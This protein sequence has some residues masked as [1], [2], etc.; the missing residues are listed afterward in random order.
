MI[1]PDPTNFYTF[2]TL[3]PLMPPFIADFDTGAPGWSVF[4]GE[5]SQSEWTLGVPNNGVE[6]AAHSP[7]NAWGSSLNGDNLDFIDTFLISPAISLVGGNSARVQFWHSYDFTEL[8]EFDLITGGE[9]LLITNANAA[10]VVLATYFDSN[11]GWEQEELD[12][13]PYLGRVI[14]L[15]W[16][17]QMLSFETAARP[18]WLVDDVAITTTAITPGT[19]LV[20]NNLSQA[21]FTIAGPV[22]VSG[23]GNSFVMTNALP[24]EYRVTFGSVPYYNTP[25][26]QT[27]SVVALSTTVFTGSYTII[28]TNDN[29]M[30]DNWERQYFGGA[31]PT[32]TEFTDTDGDGMTDNAEFLAGTNPTNS[33]SN[34][35]FLTPV[36]QNTGA[37][38]FDWPSVPGRS[39]RL[40]GS[41]DL[42]TWNPIGGWVRANSGV[43]SFTTTLT[44]GT[45]FL[46]LEV[47]P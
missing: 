47:R 35:R 19:L 31:A 22:N 42:I 34:L 32:R 39:Y 25:P 21:T 1:A 26:P 14:Y 16:H 28:D 17:H 43:L 4:N 11:F 27:N 36:V 5:D 3:V 20:T 8:T 15:V 13:T 45:R 7:P 10:P 40:T 33:T 37:V 23:Q 46:R 24:G 18:G 41:D 44:N 2:R 9:L 30:A 12:L 6:S 38:R 29:G